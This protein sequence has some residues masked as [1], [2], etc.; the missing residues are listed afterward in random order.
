MVRF[1]MVRLGKIL[2]IAMKRN[3]FLKDCAL[4]M[5]KTC[6]CLFMDKVYCRKK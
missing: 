5:K 1:K 6:S 4:F 3:V 2:G